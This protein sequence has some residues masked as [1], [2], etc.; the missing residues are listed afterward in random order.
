MLCHHQWL[1]YI[2][3]SIH[4]QLEIHTGALVAISATWNLELGS[5]GRCYRGGSEC[6]LSWQQR[7]CNRP[8]WLF[9]LLPRQGAGSVIAPEQRKTQDAIATQRKRSCESSLAGCFSLLSGCL[10]Q[11]ALSLAVSA[12]SVLC[13][14]DCLNGGSVIAEVG[15]QRRICLG[16]NT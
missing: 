4:L 11:P 9:Q 10:F 6:Q 3:C 14:L 5:S 1:H 16:H 13:V 15:C 7:K 2:C 8:N 12:C